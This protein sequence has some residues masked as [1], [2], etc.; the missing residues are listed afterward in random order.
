MEV[1]AAIDY[2]I[3]PTVLE[4][5]LY[6]FRRILS[7]TEAYLQ[8]LLRYVRVQQPVFS[9]IGLVTWSDA[10]RQIQKCLT[11]AGKGVS[12]PVLFDTKLWFG[13]HV[14][15]HFKTTRLKKDQYSILRPNISVL[16]SLLP[17]N[18]WSFRRT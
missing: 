18:H 3:P 8:A 10:D 1:F 9:L 6:G 5:H 4:K 7:P 15:M 16:N 14:C 13:W 17:A 11:L 12:K 2:G